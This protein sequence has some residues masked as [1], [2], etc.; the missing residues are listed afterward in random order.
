MQVKSTGLGTL[1]VTIDGQT[2]HGLTLDSVSR[3]DGEI[4]ISVADWID[5]GGV[6]GRFVQPTPSLADFDAAIRANIDTVARERDFDSAT[7]A[8][9][10]TQSTQA[11]WSAESLAFIAWRDQVWLYASDKLAKVQSGQTA[12]TIEEF[13]AEIPAIVWPQS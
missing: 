8:A 2:H 9:A 6:I 1:A 12:P 4:A 7:D 5:A 11:E 13:L 10:Y 3:R